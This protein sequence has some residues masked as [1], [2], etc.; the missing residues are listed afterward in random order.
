MPTSLKAYLV[1][2]WN[3]RDAAGGW[4]DFVGSMADLD[5]AVS[6]AKAKGDRWQVVGTGDGA[7]V[8]RWDREAA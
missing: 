5:A 7:V 2:A 3:G 6:F 1:F 4:G 8:R